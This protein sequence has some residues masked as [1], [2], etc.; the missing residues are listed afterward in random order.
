MNVNF[1]REL[2]RIEK[3][4]VAED[5]LLAEKLATFEQITA[6]WPRGC[7]VDQAGSGCGGRCRTSQGGGGSRCGASATDDNAARCG[8]RRREPGMIGETPPGAERRHHVFLLAALV[9][10]LLAL[11]SA[12]AAGTSTDHPRPSQVVT[13]Y[14][15]GAG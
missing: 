5:P 8:A 15:A 12:L 3:Q 2:A 4:L 9:L 6:P 14:P 10:A 7:L 11:T 13:G 1:E